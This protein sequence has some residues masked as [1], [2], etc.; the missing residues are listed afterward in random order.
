MRNQY[1]FIGTSVPPAARR[2]V[3]ITDNR[4]WKSKCRDSAIGKD[5]LNQ[6]TE[7][8][9][10]IDRAVKEKFILWNVS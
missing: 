5:V 9:E 2:F 10:A 1:L 6:L 3:R 8:L 4:S 7:L